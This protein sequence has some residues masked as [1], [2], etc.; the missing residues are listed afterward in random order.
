MHSV[1]AVCVCMC[2][3]ACAVLFNDLHFDIL[4]QCVG[5]CIPLLSGG[6]RISLCLEIFLFSGQLQ[7][8]TDPLL[9]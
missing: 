1:S 8:Y 4:K 6:N 7:D 3:H 9:P 2:V 5:Y